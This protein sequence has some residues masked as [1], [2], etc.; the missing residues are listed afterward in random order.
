M[1]GGDH[2]VRGSGRHDA[3]DPYV[4]NVH[5]AGV[6]H[7]KFLKMHPSLGRANFRVDRL[8]GHRQDFGRHVQPHGQKPGNRR[9]RPSLRAEAGPNQVSGH[10]PIAE[11]EP[12]FL[13]EPA[14]GIEGRKGIALDPPSLDGIDDTRQCIEQCID[15]G[16]Y[17]ET[18][19]LD[20]VRRVGDD[21][22]P[23]G[24]HSRGHLPDEL[25]RA[26]AARK[27]GDAIMCIHG[28]ER[29]FRTG[30]LQDPII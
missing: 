7:K 20:V 30:R 3:V 15:I 9:G 29:N 5:A 12:R 21:A 13:P 22:E 25:G 27:E 24:I 26:N 18:V 17:I 8:I 1:N 10:V 4:E 2:R 6:L 28:G 19:A 11:A 23:R 16:A 14:E